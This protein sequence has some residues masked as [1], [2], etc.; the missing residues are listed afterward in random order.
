M[1]TH[2][3]VLDLLSH[4]TSSWPFLSI[5]SRNEGQLDGLQDTLQ[6][7]YSFCSTCQGAFILILSLF[8]L[9]LNIINL[10]HSVPNCCADLGT[11]PVCSSAGADLTAWDWSNRMH[12]SMSTKIS[13]EILLGNYTDLSS[14]GRHTEGSSETRSP[15]P[16]PK[17]HDSCL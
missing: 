16:Q 5:L 14:S 1:M 11:K 15:F 10:T 7:I 2:V 13:Q 12:F 17:E 9:F 4:K 6:H 3:S 8:V